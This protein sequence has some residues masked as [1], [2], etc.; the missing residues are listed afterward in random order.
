LLRGVSPNERSS[1]DS[2]DLSAMHSAAKAGNHYCIEMMHQVI[3]R[4]PGS[5]N[6]KRPDLAINSFKT[7]KSSKMKKGQ[8][9]LKIRFKN[10]D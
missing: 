1:P 4:L 8:L 7:A 2:P 10:L 9:S 3:S 6:L 5:K